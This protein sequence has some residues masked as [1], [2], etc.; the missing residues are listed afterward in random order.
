MR[1]IKFT[2]KKFFKFIKNSVE[3]SK[4]VVHRVQKGKLL[5][6]II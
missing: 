3:N 5:I 2:E 4:C 1:V 6:I